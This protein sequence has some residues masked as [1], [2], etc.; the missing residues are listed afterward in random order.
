MPNDLRDKF[1]ERFGGTSRLFRAPGR[2]NLIGEHTDYNEGFVMPAAI[3]FSCWVAIG[4]RTDRRLGIFSE[5]M[6][7]TSECDLASGVPHPSR[8]WSDYPIGVAVMLERSG[9]SLRGANLYIRSEVPLGAGLS[10]SAAIEVSV[11][12]ALLQVCGYEVDPVRLALLCQSAENEFVGARC[13]I[14]DQFTACYG[15]AGQA[16]ML[17]CRTLDCRALHLPANVDLVV[18]NTMVRHQLAAGEY[19]TRRAEC[20]D[21]VK[22]LAAVLP[23]VHALRD[24]TSS[25]LEKH[26]FC[27]TPTLY[28]RARHIVTENERVRLAATALERGDLVAMREL[29]ASS[30]RS[31][32]DDYQVSCAELDAMVDI[33][34]RQP[35]V[36]GAR[37]TG[38]GFGGCTINLVDKEHSTAFRRTVA[39]AYHSAT[40]LQPDVYVCRASA[41]V[42]EVPSEKREAQ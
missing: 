34:G 16:L 5:N 29:M 38:G 17:D 25:D 32:R 40:G 37:M 33:A 42:E 41:G 14:M 6:Q 39:E 4:P 36:Y 26:R 35:G 7:Q 28:R 8:N 18:C 20:E 1:R 27:L 24:V 9:Y 19:N 21:A 31:L 13:G 12:F 23:G 11:G 22:R 10:S 2:V 15:R 30:H 3:D